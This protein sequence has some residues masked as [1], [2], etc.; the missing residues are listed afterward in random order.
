[1][2]SFVLLHR[3]AGLALAVLLAVIAAGCDSRPTRVPVV[4]KVLI[5]GQ[6]LTKGFVT[7]VPTDGRAATGQIQPDGTFRLTTFDENDGCLPGTHAVTVVANEQITPTR[8]KWL[9]PKKYADVGTSDK[10]VMID[11]SKADVTIELSWEGGR[12]FI[13]DTSAGDGTGP[14][15]AA[16]AT[17]A[18]QN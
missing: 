2:P 17:R 8:M 15:P 10:T 1:M 12:P 7:V 16:K 3:R 18:G 14:S 11:K 9:A 6:P 13:E 4:G 5:D